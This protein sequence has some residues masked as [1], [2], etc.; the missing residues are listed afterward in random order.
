MNYHCVL[1]LRTLQVPGT[2]ALPSRYSYSKTSPHGAEG[3]ENSMQAVGS[4][5]WAPPSSRSPRCSYKVPFC[6]SLHR[7]FTPQPLLLHTLQS[8]TLSPISEHPDALAPS[9]PEALNMEGLRW[10]L[11]PAPERPVTPQWQAGKGL[12]LPPPSPLTTGGMQTCLTVNGRSFFP[13]K[14]LI[15]Q[16]SQSHLS[17]QCTPFP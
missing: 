8:G 10:C 7:L 13:Q 11:P 9:L 14:G 3:R 2:R 17:P 4:S 15:P 6:F 16:D 1:A 12:H 5:G